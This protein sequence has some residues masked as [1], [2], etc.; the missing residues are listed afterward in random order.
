MFST[1]TD[2]HKW[3][4]PSSIL[5]VPRTFPDLSHFGVVFKATQESKVFSKLRSQNTKYSLLSKI[6]HDDLRKTICCPYHSSVIGVKPEPTNTKDQILLQQN[7]QN[8]ISNFQPHTL[9]LLHLIFLHKPIC[10]HNTQSLIPNPIPHPMSLLPR[11]P[12][13]PFARG[14]QIRCVTLKQDKNITMIARFLG[15]SWWFIY[16]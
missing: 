13:L 9:L 2:R 8:A 10:P 4:P 16:F 7:Q 6:F 1:S 3:L 11:S 14:G 12:M 15:G 5:C